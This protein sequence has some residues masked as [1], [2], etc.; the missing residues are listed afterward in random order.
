MSPFEGFKGKLEHSLERIW[1][2]NFEDE[3]TTEA[4]GDVAHLGY[5]GQAS[6]LSHPRLNPMLGTV[7]DPYW[8]RK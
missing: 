7:P 3:V 4:I 1:P 8:G 6:V 2:K 5:G